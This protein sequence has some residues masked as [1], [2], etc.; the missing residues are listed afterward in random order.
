MKNYN[1]KF[2]IKKIKA[3]EILD[4]KGEPT[5]EAEV[6]TEQGIFRAS[7]PSGVSRGKYEA[8]ELRDGGKR[9]FGKG[10]LRA[11]KNVN[12][13]IGPEL[14]GKDATLQKEIDE[15]LIKLDGTENKSKLGA[16]AILGVSMA[17]CRAGAATNKLPLWKW[18]SKIAERTPILSTPC[19]LSMEGGLHGQSH[20]DV[21]EFMVVSGADSFREKLRVGT[22]IYH[23]LGSILSK[24][25][26]KSTTN[27]GVEGG[28]TPP[29]K[30]TEEALDLVME[31]IK[32]A[33]YENKV[34]IIL[35]IAASSFFR[36]GKYYFEKG[37]LSGEKL[38]DFYAELLKKY[39]I[40]AI[41]DPFAQDDWEGFQ[42]ITQ[43]L[44]RR[45][46][47]IGDDLLVTNL[48]RIREAIERR[49]CNGLILKPNQIGTVSET[50]EAAKY[51]I[52]NGWKVFVKHRGGETSDD[53]IADL[54]VGLG[55]GWIM[56]G[57]PARGE[58]V[59]KYNRLL[60]IE[61]EL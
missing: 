24:R 7:V 1:S 29:L 11:V 23:I 28:F 8:V 3:R 33:G 13:I 61:E 30:E 46:T 18:I 10:V 12:E 16:N 42:K 17:C 60:R 26:G 5:V 52:Q 6:E 9:F 39:P 45:I 36:D 21:Q 41:E 57:A 15:F 50:I 31:A 20:L 37:I 43:D 40:L 49:A 4:S 59:A 19:I 55:T 56:A 25:Y 38:L 44:G 22:E 53:F 2:K 32:K 51:A 34:K 27:V 47:I 54:S 58:R 14:K 48:Q 35:D